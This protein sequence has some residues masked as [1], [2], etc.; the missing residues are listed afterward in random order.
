MEKSTFSLQIYGIANCDTIKMA[1]AWLTKHQVDYYFHDF[2]K[3]GVPAAELEQWIDFFGWETMVNRQGTTWRKLPLEQ[4]ERLKTRVGA[5]EAFCLHPSMIRRPVAHWANNDQAG[6]GDA[7]TLGFDT[8]GWQENLK[9]F[10]FQQELP[11][12]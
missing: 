10:N 12:S 5:A 7:I 11:S 1:R 9:K 6:G 8:V 3:S 4:Q 2:K